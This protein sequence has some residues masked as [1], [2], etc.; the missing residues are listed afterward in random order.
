MSGIDVEVVYALRDVQESVRLRLETGATA[1]DA[2]N[3]SGIQRR[4]PE[5]RVEAGYLGVY[6]RLC[7]PD[8]V[9]QDGDRVEIYR[10]LITD[11]KQARLRRARAAAT[12]KASRAGR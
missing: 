5:I 2:V 9:L 1:R 11:P 7:D 4:Y 8:Q 6:S 10:P 3:A 12:G